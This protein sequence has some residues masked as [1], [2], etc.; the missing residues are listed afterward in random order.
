MRKWFLWV[1]KLSITS[2]ILYYI[3]KI[4]PFSEVITS[5][6]SAKVSYIIV[7]LLISP[8]VKYVEAY[9]MRILSDNQGMSLSTPQIYEINFVTS[10]YGFF[11][12]NF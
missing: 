4:I 10:F 5:I 7:G 6:I 9:R 2:G 8:F 12:R 11:C 3:F 1:L